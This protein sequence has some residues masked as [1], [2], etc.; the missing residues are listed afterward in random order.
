MIFDEHS[1]KDIIIS[2][3]A[4]AAKASA[5]IRCAQK[6]LMQAESRMKFLLSAVHY[7]KQEICDE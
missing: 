4:E 7:L 1:R 3:I 2:L 5:E 6:D